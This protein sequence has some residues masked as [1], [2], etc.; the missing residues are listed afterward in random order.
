M[1]VDLERML[2]RCVQGQWSV[3]DFD[4]TGSPIPL[5]AEQETQVCAYYVNMSY[6]ERLAGALFRSLSERT[7]DPTLRAIFRTFVD[8]EVRH[9]QAAARLAD[10]FDVH[11]YRVYTPN[12]PMLRFIPY[13]VGMIDSMSPAFAQSFI[14]G[15]ELILD[16]AL[17]RSLNAYVDD[18]LARAVV[19][20][21]NQDES[22]HLAMDMHMTEL[23]ARPAEAKIETTGPWPGAD[24][25]G[26]LA[27]GPAFFSEVF[28]RP[29]QVLDPGQEKM[30]DVMR[31]F[32][33]FYDRSTVSGN[34]AVEQFRGIV[35][36]AESPLGTW[37][38]TGLETFFR[39]VMG[40]DFAFVH[41]ASSEALYGDGTPT[42]GLAPAAA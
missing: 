9:S 3:D 30:R 17:L 32:R 13:F 12:L 24:F 1:A 5:S 37:V 39:R 42:A 28:F 11:H 10:Y 29:M 25:W 33:R 36:F 22:R 21:I 23:F 14:L 8:D 26:V 34:P 40:V 27:W 41:A 35:A 15:G 7:D 18:P 2:E 6:I 38:G 20:R 31:R 16:I 4:W 19:E